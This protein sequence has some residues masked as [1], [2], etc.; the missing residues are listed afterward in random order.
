MNEN[1]DHNKGPEELRRRAEA[2]RSKLDE[3]AELQEEVK[4]I[5]SEAKADGFD[6]KALAQVVKELRRGPEFQEAQ[7]QLEL[8]LDTYRRNVGLPVTLDAAQEANRKE[9][10]QLPPEK[11]SRKKAATGEARGRSKDKLN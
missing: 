8:V 4:V 7:L 11:P 3:I 5:K 10:E 2:L 1:F 6:M 9:A